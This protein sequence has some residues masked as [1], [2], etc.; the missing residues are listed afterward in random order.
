MSIK[1][2]T[3]VWAT[4]ELKHGR[5]ILMLALADH[6]NDAGEC[7]PSQPH[8]EE[9]TRLTDRQLRRVIHE[10]CKSNFLAVAEKGVG[11]GKKTVYRL[12]PQS[13]EKADILSETKADIMTEKSGQNVQIKADISAQKADIFDADQ[14]HA[15][16]EPP[17][18]PSEQPSMESS[19]SSED[20]ED[21]IAAASAIDEAWERRYGQMMPESVMPAMN[22]LIAECG[23][24]AVVH[25]IHSAAD[26]GARTFAYIAQ[27]ARNYIPP[28]TNG[29]TKSYQ[30]DLAPPPPVRVVST[31]AP[32][33]ASSLDTSDP[34]RVC[35]PELARNLHPNYAAR[36][37]G[38]RLEPAGHITDAQGRAVPLYRVVVTDPEAIRAAPTLNLQ[39]G[40]AIRRAVKSVIGDVQI[41]IVAAAE[42]E[43]EPTP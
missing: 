28:A 3:R 1:Y 43:L 33:P 17:L 16:S 13:Q 29:P 37:V 39:L 42:V 24:V 35:L 8:L 34:W 4:Q 7:W 12:F 10:L 22:K 14:S 9:K 15:R 30:V 31:N 41:E 20:E 36:L 23:V 25:G 27:C 6:A 2:M 19:S 5:L 40:G 21:G 18:Q 32:A 38:S 11:R 26:N